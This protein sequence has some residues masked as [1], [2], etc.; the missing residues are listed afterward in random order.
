MI[1]ED[2]LLIPPDWKAEV[3]V[4]RIWR[5]AAQRS[6][7][8]KSSRQGL[9][10]VPHLSMSYRLETMTADET[11][12]LRRRLYASMHLILGCPLWP[13]R[14]DLTSTAAADQAIL[15]LDTTKR[16][17]EVGA[18]VILLSGID[19]YEVGLVQSFTDS[20][21]VLEEALASAWPAGTAVYPLLQGKPT[22]ASTRIVSDTDETGGM[23]VEIVESFDTDI[24]HRVEAWSGTTY[25]GIPVLTVQPDW[26]SP[27][28]QSHDRPS[29]RTAGQWEENESWHYDEPTL[30]MM[31]SWW[32]T[33][34]SDVMEVA[35]F[36]DHIMGGLRAFWAPTWHGDIR[37]ADGFGLD[38]TVL[39]IA[40]GLPSEWQ[41]NDVIGLHLAIVYPDGTMIFRQ[42]SDAATDS[43]TLSCA[44]GKAMSAAELPQALV[45]YLLLVRST[46]D[47][48]ELA[49]EAE[50]TASI[51]MTMETLQAQLVT[52]TTTTTTTTAPE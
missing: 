27:I 25:G 26:S 11:D 32:E 23:D 43:I 48:L 47:V 31:L 3:K 36:F 44:T 1:A 30:L 29:T 19:D 42:I 12:Y 7:T 52:I 40:G 51:S 5:T 33:G 14:S 39:S 22:L 2:Y 24:T 4:R 38:D 50:E 20:Q 15:A 16:H 41:G 17:F 46:S 37:L 35:G 10:S 34:R 6:V 9:Y 13:D 28:E 45:C 18:P 8:G 21:I 49:Y